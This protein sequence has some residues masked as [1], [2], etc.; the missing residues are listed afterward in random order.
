MYFP[1]IK[2]KAIQ[3]RKDGYS[4]NHIVKHV[5]VSKSTLSEWLH[6]VPFIPNQ[7][8]KDAIGNARI[9]SGVFKHQV[10]VKSLEK[11][12]LQA[13]EDIGILSSRDVMMLGLGIYIGEGS[14]TFNITRISNSDPKIIKLMI[15]WLQISFAIEEKQVRVR[16]HIYP[17]S[18]ESECIKYWS[19]EIGILE[20]QFYKSTIDHRNNKKSDKHGKLPFGTAHVSVKSFGN[21]IHG[22]YLHRRIMAWI[23][24]VL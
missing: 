12:E 2:Q 24:K 7:Y 4:Y 23:N 10:K 15:K 22:V 18:I 3:L 8:T 9:A 16:L 17:D 20:S 19:K 13:K 5:P 1:E 11:A 14:K 21:G 6:D